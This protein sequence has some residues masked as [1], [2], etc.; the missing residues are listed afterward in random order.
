MGNSPM[1]RSWS[2]AGSSKGVLALLFACF[3]LMAGP[4]CRAQTANFS[5]AHTTELYTARGT[6]LIPVTP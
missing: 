5:G 1:D 4:V 6:A 2:C 3:R